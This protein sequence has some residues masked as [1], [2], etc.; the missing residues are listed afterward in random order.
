MIMKELYENT[1]EK[2][3]HF[4]FGKNWQQ[5]LK[6]VTPERI[7][8]AK[9]SLSDFLGEETIK[10]KTFIDIG[11]GSGLFS[12]AAVLLGSKNVVSIDIDDF[13]LEC[14]TYLKKEFAPQASWNI[15]K[16]SALD[17]KLLLSLGQFDI[18]YS[19][20]VLHH[21]GDMYRAFNN[22][23]SLVRPSGLLFLAIY[24]K[25][26]ISDGIMQSI[27]V[28]TSNFWLKIKYLYNKGGFSTKKIII[29]LYYI[30]YL[31]ISILTL[32]NPFKR[33]KKLRRA[34]DFHIN[35]IDWL[36]GYPYEYATS[37]ELIKYF[38]KSG[39][40]CVN[41]QSARTLGCHQILFRRFVK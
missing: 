34:M 16:S 33:N 5:F 22:A 14:A 19:W 30:Y 29:V 25:F 9:K 15:I 32:N 41:I 38:A 18:V 8:E 24:N 37:D 31:L 17:E 10:D 23:M 27:F 39:F 13:S 28:G 3:D 7:E 40:F 2:K 26:S 11:C 35:V 4:S 21:T 36:G 12:L 20:G 6:K 1:Y